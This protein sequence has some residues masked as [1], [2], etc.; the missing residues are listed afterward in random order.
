V[1][2]KG[3]GRNPSGNRLTEAGQL[4]LQSSSW[5]DGDW[6]LLAPSTRQAARFRICCTRPAMDTEAISIAEQFESLILSVQQLLGDVFGEISASHQ[7]GKRAVSTP[8]SRLH[9]L[10]RL[11]D[12]VQESANM[13]RSNAV[14]VWPGP[15]EVPGDHRSLFELG[16]VVELLRNEGVAQGAWESL[17][18]TLATPSSYDHAIVSLALI[19]VLKNWGLKAEMIPEDSQSRLPDLKL[20][21]DDPT[22]SVFVEVKTKESL[23]DPEAPID[24][25][26]A[27]KLIEAA[28]KSVGSGQRSQLNGCNTA[29]LA[30]GGYGIRRDELVL[31]RKAALARLRNHGQRRKHLEAVVF[32]SV[33]VNPDASTLGPDGAPSVGTRWGSA[34]EF[35]RVHNP[36]YTG[37]WKVVMLRDPKPR[38]RGA[39]FFSRW[40]APR[41]RKD[42]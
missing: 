24:Y 25:A 5:A 11:I 14:A 35:E 23:I 31:L 9:R 32:L 33:D 13:M 29:W 21:G 38:L 28:F 4:E 10:M 19:R 20:W 7:R 1:E 42:L 30:I 15:L 26:V 41:V 18:K 22:Q 37:N 27:T 34:V 36:W 6:P 8:P 3:V 12:D 40:N 17:R 39:D 2:S 16:S